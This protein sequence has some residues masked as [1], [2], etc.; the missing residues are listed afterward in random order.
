M[1]TPCVN[2]AARAVA[3]VPVQVPPGLGEEARRQLAE[4]QRHIVSGLLARA[5]DADA[6][7]AKR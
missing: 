5:A 4:A 1:R 2:A 6:A 3:A 7:L